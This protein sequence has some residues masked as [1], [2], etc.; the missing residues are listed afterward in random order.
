MDKKAVLDRTDVEVSNEEILKATATR[1]GLGLREDEG[2]EE[3]EQGDRRSKYQPLFHH[4]LPFSF[5]KFHHE[6]LLR[7]ILLLPLEKQPLAAASFQDSWVLEEL[8]LRGREMEVSDENGLTPL[9]LACSQ[10]DID[11]TILLLHIGCNVNAETIDGSTPLFMALSS[12]QSHLTSLL[13]EHGALLAVPKISGEDA[14]FRTTLDV[15][16]PDEEAYRRARGHSGHRTRHDGVYLVTDQQSKET[17]AMN[18]HL[19]Y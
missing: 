19:T 8:Y 14:G 17:G 2:K 6:E 7:K 9:H 1:T 12:G 16:L 4:P 18:S 11:S 3:E 13:E 5:N 10:G 15:L